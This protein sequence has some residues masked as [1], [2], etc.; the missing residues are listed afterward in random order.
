MEN[1][2]LEYK[3]GKIKTNLKIENVERFFIF[4][5]RIDSQQLY[6]TSSDK[7]LK[8]EDIQFIN[9]DLKKQRII[10]NNSWYGEYPL[11]YYYDKVMDLILIDY[12]L[13]ELVK[14]IQKNH[15]KL[16]LDRTAFFE[17]C[18]IDNPLRSRTLFKNVYK[19]MAGEEISFDLKKFEV[20]KE[21]VFKLQFNGN[22]SEKNEELYLRDAKDIL[23]SLFDKYEEELLHCQEED[24]LIPLSGGYDSRLLA[25]LANRKG[26][27][28]NSLVF[29]P[30]H[31]NEIT[32]ARKVADELNLNLNVEEL[33][34]SYYEKYGE[35]VVGLTGGLS[36]P[37]H[38]H[39]YSVM[40]EKQISPKYIIHGFLGGE[41]AGANQTKIAENFSMTKEEAIEDVINRRFKG[42]TLWAQID[43]K[44]KEE[45][46][47]DVK[48]LAEDCCQVNLP[49]HLDE[50][51]R[52]VDRQNSLI[53]NIFAPLERESRI[54]RPF[55]SKDYAKFFNGLPYELRENRY[56]YKKA[57]LSLFPET[58]EIPD[59]KL[60]SNIPIPKKLQPKVR[61]LFLG[62]FVL[63]YLVS[64]GKIQIGKS[65][66]YEKH[67]ELLDN[68]LK[69]VLNKSIEFSTEYTGI[70]FYK[71]AKPSYVRFKE[72]L[73]PFR[74]ITLY[75]LQ[76]YFRA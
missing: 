64:K 16:E 31:S 35:E 14:A 49:C 39:L 3:R 67:H 37:M 27:K 8:S 26:F 29:G 41:F 33:L 51:I 47:N 57:S 68:E 50:Y 15:I 13:I 24:T 6:T 45:I 58:F 20:K 25:S 38:C 42:H 61:K 44:E 70:D 75:Y 71:Y 73:V 54:I 40:Q 72:T 21:R 11:F 34:N 2:L 28:F 17:E 76:E 4:P 23:G 12:N 74:L 69:D 7:F 46:I 22:H 56:L 36:S 59:Q 5:S 65:M 60:P 66:V 10:I 48:K 43:T 18:I 55:A 62:A 63:S 19:C 52:N 9:Y 30:S 1:I 32:V 53:A